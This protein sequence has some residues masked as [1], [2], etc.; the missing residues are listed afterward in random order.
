MLKKLSREFVC[1]ILARWLDRDPFLFLDQDPCSGFAFA[2]GPGGLDTESSDGSM[3]NGHKPQINLDL[4]IPDTH[5]VRVR[6]P[7]HLPPRPG[8]ITL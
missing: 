3:I 2:S 1:P 4:N 5:P 6:S 7:D 8:I